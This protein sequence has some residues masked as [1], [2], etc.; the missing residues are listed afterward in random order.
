MFGYDW[1]C[2]RA[3]CLYLGLVCM[4]GPLFGARIHVWASVK[5]LNVCLGMY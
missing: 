1:A 4:F 5:G 3:L 2:I